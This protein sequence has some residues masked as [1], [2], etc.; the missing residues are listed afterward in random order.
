M[1]TV[2]WNWLVS[3]HNMWCFNVESK[4]LSKHS[5]NFPMCRHKNPLLPVIF[6]RQ[7]TPS[8]F[9]TVKSPARRCRIPTWDPSVTLCDSLPKTQTLSSQKDLPWESLFQTTRYKL[10]RKN[11][12]LSKSCD[13]QGESVNLCV[14]GPT[15][16]TWSRIDTMGGEALGDGIAVEARQAGKDYATSPPREAVMV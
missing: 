12:C 1:D 8:A 5:N 14:L 11:L 3:C 7:I 13:V 16:K 4:A 10:A 2:R 6:H 15:E 9:F